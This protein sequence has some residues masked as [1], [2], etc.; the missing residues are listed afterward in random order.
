MGGSLVVKN[1]IAALMH[2]LLLSAHAV[3]HAHNLFLFGYRPRKRETEISNL[4][5]EV[6]G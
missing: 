1:S 4:C 3:P 6:L 5:P 2:A